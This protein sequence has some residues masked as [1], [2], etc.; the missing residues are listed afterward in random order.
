MGYPPRQKK[1]AHMAK[2]NSNLHFSSGLERYGMPDHF[3]LVPLRPS[4]MPPDSSDPALKSCN[5]SD[6]SSLHARK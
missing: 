1:Q 4:D 6:A 5:P 3:D 2:P